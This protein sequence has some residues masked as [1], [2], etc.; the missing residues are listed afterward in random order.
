MKL[1]SDELLY[2][3]KSVFVAQTD[4]YTGDIFSFGRHPVK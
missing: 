4:A 3:C 2:R 1:V